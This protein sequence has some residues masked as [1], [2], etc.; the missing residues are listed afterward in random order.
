MRDLKQLYKYFKKTLFV[1]L[2]L[3]GIAPVF[4]QQDTTLFY[5]VE[6]KI[7]DSKSGS[8]V[9]YASIIILGTNTG[10]IANMEGEF[11]FKI[12]TENIGDSIV[13]SSIGYKNKVF[14][15]M[16]FRSEGHR[17]QLE[18]AAIS[19]AEVNIRPG[20]AREI[21]IAAMDNIRDN[22]SSNPYMV[23]AFYRES[24]QR[25][26]KYVAVSEAV[27]DAYKSPYTGFERDRVKILKARKSSDFQMKD[28][29]ALKLQGGPYSMFRLDFVKNPGELLER[30]ILPDYEFKIEGQVIVDNKLAY[31]ISFEQSPEITVP[32]YEGKFYIEADKL[33]FLGAEFQINEDLIH[34]AHEYMVKQKPQ[35]VD[36][37][38]KKAS[39]KVSYR[40]FGGNWHLSY[41]RAELSMFMRWKKKH[42]RATYT[43]TAEMAITDMDTLNITKF[44]NQ[45][46]L[47]IRDVL[48][49]QVG[50]F[51]DPDFWGQYNIIR[52][53]ESIQSAIK[54]M[55]R[56]LRRKNKS[57]SE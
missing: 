25:K 20:N 37:E 52:P 24:I 17:I 18:S 5:K 43:T 48:I 46:T 56:K 1:G 55:G 45:N 26:R 44:K 49:E 51:E 8:P 31:V 10:T 33:A 36:V 12:L 13:I 54:K 42:F 39:Y 35:G 57:G 23:T 38:I 11:V 14:S 40:F 27:L 29:L 2:L 30:E 19:L 3:M 28:T 53:E 15:S 34:K 16:Q 32:L 47:G 4:A 41:V 6:G 9:V 50:N 21:L 22:Y 7:V